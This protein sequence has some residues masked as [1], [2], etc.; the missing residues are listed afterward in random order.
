MW[1]GLADFSETIGLRIVSD[2]QG[3]GS[4][5]ID[6]GP[7]PQ[8]GYARDTTVTID[9]LPNE[10]WQVEE[11]VGD[12]EIL[13]DRSARIRLNARKIVVVRFLRSTNGP[14]G[15]VPLRRTTTPGNQLRHLIE[16][17]ALM[18]STSDGDAIEASPIGNVVTIDP[19]VFSDL[20]PWGFVRIWDYADPESPVLASTFNTINS[21]NEN[22]P[23]DNRGIYSVHNV[24]T[25]GSRV[26]ISG[27][28]NGVL[29]L[30]ITDPHNPVEIARYNPTGA[31]FEESNGGI[32]QVFG[33]FKPRGRNVVYASDRNGGL[34]VLE[35]GVRE[36]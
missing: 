12:V 22:G 27:Y 1:L 15:P 25:E 35:L 19:T 16:I 7:L 30:D 17:P 28:S 10:G 20:K 33:I 26:F 29:V 18:I 21:L 36:K 9:A 24:M 31:E 3:A 5:L 8:G 34:Y 14:S 32:Q 4:F 23:P 2:P 6:P 11:W 13:P